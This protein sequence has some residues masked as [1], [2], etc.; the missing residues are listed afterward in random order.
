VRLTV[1]ID[2]PHLT[3]AA[4]VAPWAGQG[5][6]RQP[7]PAYPSPNLGAWSEPVRAWRSDTIRLAINATR[8]QFVLAVA[9][10]G[11]APRECGG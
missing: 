3:L 7:L 5:T 6:V 2:G 11:D 1:T 9:V 8:N 10:K 4:A